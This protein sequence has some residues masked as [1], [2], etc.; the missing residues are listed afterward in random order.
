MKAQ[1]ILED[2]AKVE[3]ELQQSEDQGVLAK[4]DWCEWA[5]PIVPE[6]K[7]TGAVRI[8][9]DFMVTV[10]PVFTCRAVSAPAHHYKRELMMTYTWQTYRQCCQGWMSMDWEPTRASGTSLWALWSHHGRHK[11]QD[12]IHAVIKA[13]KTRECEPT[14]LIFGPHKSP[15]QVSSEPVCTL[16]TAFAATGHQ[17]GVVK[18]LYTIV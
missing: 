11:S 1:L 6:V 2:D 17:M 3:A 10:N 8:C 12:K 16:W 14:A 5:T 18:R 9:G 7:K 15:P 13:P 4:V